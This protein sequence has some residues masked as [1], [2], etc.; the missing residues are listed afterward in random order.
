VLLGPELDG[1]R[2]ELLHEVVPDRRRIAVLVDPGVTRTSL[3]VMQPVARALG[4]ELLIVPVHDSNYA[5]AF[6]TMRSQ[7]ADALAVPTSTQLLRDVAKITSLAT[8]HRLPTVCQWAEMAHAGCL[9]GYGVSLADVRR[10]S[11]HYVARILRGTPPGDLPIEQASVFEL[12]FNLKT[13]KALGVQIPAA[14][15]TRADEVIE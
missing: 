12:T 9:I 10:R 7:S 5:A 15:L 2:L 1:K 3:E 6:E 13:A 4:L 8:E 11:A 14:L